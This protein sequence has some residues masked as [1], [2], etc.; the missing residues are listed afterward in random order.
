MEKKFILHE[1]NYDGGSIESDGGLIKFSQ[2]EKSLMGD[3]PVNLDSSEF[4]LAHFYILKN[5]DEIQPFFE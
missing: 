5:Y 3:K 2:P 4:E 1:R